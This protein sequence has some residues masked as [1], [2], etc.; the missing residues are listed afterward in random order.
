MVGTCKC[1]LC[2]CL[3]LCAIVGA[4]C[5][6]NAPFKCQPMYSNHCCMIQPTLGEWSLTVVMPCWLA[7]SVICLNS[8]H[9]SA[10]HHEAVLTRKP[11]CHVP[12][13]T[14]VTISQAAVASLQL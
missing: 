9:C 8:V 2:N 11:L 3:G 6:T 7:W 12:S 4:L 10:Y 13:L 1:R 14:K 5:S